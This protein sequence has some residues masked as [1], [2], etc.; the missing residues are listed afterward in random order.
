MGFHKTEIEQYIQTLVNQFSLD[1][2][3]KQH[4]TEAELTERLKYLALYQPESFDETDLWNQEDDFNSPWLKDAK[5][6]ITWKLTPIERSVLDH[7]WKPRNFN[8]GYEVKTIKHAA[9]QAMTFKQR[10]KLDNFQYK[11]KR[12]LRNEFPQSYDPES[13]DF[14]N[15]NEAYQTRRATFV[16]KHFP[17][18]AIALNESFL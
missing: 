11:L 9:R 14:Y 5:P 10:E 6:A 17:N 8:P 16:K 3:N 15:F 12:S 13:S 2:V 7:P 4:E 18:L 1:F